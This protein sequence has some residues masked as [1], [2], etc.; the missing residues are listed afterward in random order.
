MS[1]NNDDIHEPDPLTFSLR[2]LLYFVTAVAICLGGIMFIH[3]RIALRQAEHDRHLALDREIADSLIVEIESLR[4][5]LGRAPKDIRELESLLGRPMP[6]TYAYGEEYPI[7]YFCKPDGTYR[8]DYNTE[9]WNSQTYE[10]S[11]P[12]AGWFETPF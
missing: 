2:S 3:N 7:N 4:A 5:K 12:K 10:S 1:S 6:K 11:N 9:S 8:L